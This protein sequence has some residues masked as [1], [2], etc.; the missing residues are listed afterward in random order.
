MFFVTDYSRI[1]AGW[2]E[3]MVDG[4]GNGPVFI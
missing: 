2:V 1:F 3:G 4:R